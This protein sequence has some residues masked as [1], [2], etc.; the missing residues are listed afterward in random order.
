MKTYIKIISI[1]LVIALMVNSQPPATVVNAAAT[2]ITGQ[3]QGRDQSGSI[4]PFTAIQF[5][6]QDRTT[7]DLLLEAQLP[8]GIRA[9]FAGTRPVPNQTQRID[10]YFS[11]QEAIQQQVAELSVTQAREQVKKDDLYATLVALAKSE[12]RLIP[13]A[14]CPGGACDG[15]RAAVQA[16]QSSYNLAKMA[17]QRAGTDALDAGIK[18][19]VAGAIVAAIYLV[20]AACNQFLTPIGAQIC[21]MIASE[22]LKNAMSNLK[23]ALID[24]GIALVKLVAVAI[25]EGAASD[26]LNAAQKALTE[27][28]ARNPDCSGSQMC[29]SGGCKSPTPVP[30][31]TSCPEDSCSSNGEAQLSPMQIPSGASL[32]S[33][34]QLG[35]SARFENANLSV[36]VLPGAVSEPVTLVYQSQPRVSIL[37][38]RPLLFFTLESYNQMG[39]NVWVKSDGF[40]RAVHIRYFYA[41]EALKDV[42]PK[43]IRFYAFNNSMN[44][45]FPLTGTNDPNTQEMIVKVDRFP[46][47]ATLYAIMAPGAV[48]ANN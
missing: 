14:D 8:G 13:P 16:R 3:N 20:I 12:E 31:P 44:Q 36:E 37:G 43:N 28:T 15:A 25:E 42:D 6:T 30:K 33:L 23:W 19:A 21:I 45:W 5:R 32:A 9:I 39:C 35:G 10:E 2:T 40:K 17:T 1:F 41:S 27:C 29:T 34:D 47:N 24:L 46:T 22:A 26:A 18:A 7:N 38:M 11:A 4:S 48:T